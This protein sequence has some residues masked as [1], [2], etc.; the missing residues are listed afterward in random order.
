MLF[1][2]LLFLGML[3]DKKITI[4]FGKTKICIINLPPEKSTAAVLTTHTHTLIN[5]KK[6]NNPKL[7]RRKLYAVILSIFLRTHYW[8]GSPIYSCVSRIRKIKIR[9][10]Q[11]SN[12]T[13]SENIL[14]TLFPCWL[15]IEIT[16]THT[17]MLPIKISVWFQL[18]LDAHTQTNKQTHINV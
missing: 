6:I 5:R 1:F 11:F 9:H 10:R 12:S 7:I 16:H 3:D 2:F 8:L 13:L 14:D 4:L 15:L 17:T 18:I